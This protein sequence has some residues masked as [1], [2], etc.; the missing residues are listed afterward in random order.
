MKKNV[1]PPGGAYMPPGSPPQ[2]IAA[3]NGFSVVYNGKPLLSLI[4][5]PRSAERLIAA[6]L[7][8]KERTLYLCP[9]P[10][11]GYGLARFAEN[12]PQN[13]KLLCVEADK[14]LYEWTLGN[15]DCQTHFQPF[16]FHT[17]DPLELCRRASEK[18]G[19]RV[20][21]RIEVIKLTGGY[22]LF[23]ELYDNFAETLRR[24]IQIEWG[25]AMTLSRLGRL[26]IRNAIRNAPRLAGNTI[27]G[28][29][30]GSSPVLVA[31][32]GPS[33]DNFLDFLDGREKTFAVIAVDTATGPLL[34]RGIKPD[35]VVALEAQHWN[36]K[37]FIGSGGVSVPIAMDLSALPATAECL[38]GDPLLFF[39]PWTDL[40]LFSR[41]ASANLLPPP[42]PPLGSVGLSAVSLAGRLSTGACICAGLDFSFTLDKY[43]C[44][45]SPTHLAFLR[46][47]TRLTSLYPAAAAFRSGTASALSK[48]GTAVRTDAALCNYRDLFEREFGGSKR[49]FD[50]EGSGL[51]LGLQTLTFE[52]AARE[53]EGGGGDS[54]SG[55]RLNRRAD[56]T[57]TCTADAEQSLKKEKL[58]AFVKNECGIL[59]EILDILTGKT[60]AVSG[61]LEVLLD[62]ADYLWAH[63]PDCAG[64][65]GRRPPGTDS[66]FLKR[67]RAEI[68]PFL[69]L[70]T[71]IIAKNTGYSAAG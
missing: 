70:W 59:S 63:F 54:T 14:I 25:N 44:K 39:T 46:N 26:Y 67:V 13:S 7:P 47:C 62:E 6:L 4:D 36:I 69:W 71:R 30:F 38:S 28:I 16:I 17:R 2:K 51:P 18:W 45:G 15:F 22:N 56:E 20:F 19:R 53:L 3:K 66:G 64:G 21:R 41:L 34:R 60:R 42:L 58:A 29:D 57:N 23:P 24:A 68:E 52:E 65:G 48:S 61:R 9:S 12:L 40:R 10:L 11:F 1:A 27:A 43:H 31:G 50:I 37:D 8:A 33:L 32:A 49:L 55:F 5:P 35:L